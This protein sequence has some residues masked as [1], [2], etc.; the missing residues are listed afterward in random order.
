[1]DTH[2]LASQEQ[3][4]YL[5]YLLRLWRESEGERPVWRASLRSTQTG[6]KVGFGSLEELC[7]FLR[8]RIGVIPDAAVRRE[9]DVQSHDPQHTAEC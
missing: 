8:H 2:S 7:E 6:E 4:D 5:S 3:R 1:M 9:E